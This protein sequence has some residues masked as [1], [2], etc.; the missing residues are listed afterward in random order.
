MKVQKNKLNFTGFV[1]AQEIN[2]AVVSSSKGGVYID[3]PLNRKL[4]RVGMPYKKEDIK[5]DKEDKEK[6]ESEKVEIEDHI[7]QGAASHSNILN[8]LKGSR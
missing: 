4:G 5:K 3:S 1:N 8:D 7:V 6:K 2:K